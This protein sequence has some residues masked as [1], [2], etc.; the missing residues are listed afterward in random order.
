MNEIKGLLLMVL[1]A[2]GSFFMPITD[3][4]LAILVLLGINFLSGWIEDEMHGEGWRWKKA[5]KTLYECFVLCG[6]G[7]AIFVIG[8]FMH[9]EQAAVQCLSVI[10]LA[11]TWFYSVN[12][13]NNWKKIL[14]DGTTLYRYV[15]FLHFIVSMKFVEKI[16]YLKAF[17]MQEEPGQNVK[18]IKN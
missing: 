4:M 14:P 5:F 15:S 17:L 3:F 11:G 16:P 12:I 8:R 18:T 1:A 2:L 13:L 9:R 10:Y 6:I 7:A